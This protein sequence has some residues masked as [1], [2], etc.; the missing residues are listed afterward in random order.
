MKTR[1]YSFRLHFTNVY[2]IEQDGRLLLVDTGNRG[3]V[4]KALKVIRRSGFELS[5]LK[6]IFLTHTHYDHAGSAAGIK[7]QTGAKVI[8]HNSEA[9]YLRNGFTPLPLG[10]S[11][12]FKVI[13]YVGRKG[14]GLEKALARY[15][16]VDPEIVFDDTLDLKEIG[17]DGI[18]IHTPGHTEGSSSLI[19]GD[20]AFVGDTM[21][22]FKGIIFPGFAN[23]EEM[24]G[25]SWKKL[26]TPDVEQYYPAHGKKINRE[27]L[28]KEA[29]KKG[30]L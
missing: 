24:V 4:N 17:F 18:I 30:I 13:S 3:Q 16:P 9:D 20:H 10:T 14:P 21:F 11:P 8:V 7:K 12:Y 29:M 26:L 15:D 1:F 19:L 23:D 5:D 27:R 28:V 2:L 6:Y 22:N 25:E